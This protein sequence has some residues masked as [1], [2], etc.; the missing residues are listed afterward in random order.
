MTDQTD[1]TG[2]TALDRLERLVEDLRHQADRPLPRPG[3]L[4]RVLQRS[5]P[6]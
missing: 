5:K 3:A 1:Q 6:R 4:A 2:D